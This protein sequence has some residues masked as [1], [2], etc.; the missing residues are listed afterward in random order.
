MVNKDT[1]EY[2]NNTSYQ[3]FDQKLDPSI[4]IVSNL[5]SRKNSI[6]N[7]S[8]LSLNIQSEIKSQMKNS[9]ISKKSYAKFIN[10]P[11][12]ANLNSASN[13]EKG[14][15]LLKEKSYN[16][17]SLIPSRFVYTDFSGTGGDM[18]HRVSVSS[19]VKGAAT[20]LVSPDSS[21]LS[22]H[23]PNEVPQ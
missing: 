2:I 20:G 21:T 12:D 9:T 1:R 17:F 8:V 11:S 13:S 19:G 16:N 7:R 3:D 5:K 23:V 15:V 14:S 10:L 6:R 4:R 22:Q 18:L